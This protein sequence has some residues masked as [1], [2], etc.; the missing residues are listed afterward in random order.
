M[1]RVNDASHENRDDVKALGRE[2]DGKDAKQLVKDA[3]A[4]L[5][6]IR[7]LAVKAIHAT[8]DCDPHEDEDADEDADNEDED[9]NEGEGTSTTTST[10]TTTVT[11]LDFTGDAKAIADLAIALMEE[12][13]EKL[14]A[15]LAELDSDEET[16]EAT[17]N[18]NGK[19][20]KKDNKGKGNSGKGRR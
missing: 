10:T 17:T 7:Q 14:E 8:F 2:A 1:K 4:E 12:V 19:S 3:D 13:V 16:T 18:E 11:S 9:E 6:D 5:R 20:G 15:D